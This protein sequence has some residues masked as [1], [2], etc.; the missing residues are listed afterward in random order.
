MTPNRT[1]INHNRPDCHP[2]S[3]KALPG[4]SFPAAAKTPKGGDGH[5]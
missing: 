2:N 5:A 3:M 1:F 4:T